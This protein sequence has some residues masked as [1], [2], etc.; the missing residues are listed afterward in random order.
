[1]VRIFFYFIP[2]LR[3]FT[4]CL[5][6]AS[7]KKKQQQQKNTFLWGVPTPVHL[8]HNDEGRSQWVATCAHVGKE[9]KWAWGAHEP[10]NL[11]FFNAWIIFSVMTAALC[12]QAANAKLKAHFE[13]SHCIWSNS[14]Q[15]IKL[16]YSPRLLLTQKTQ[17]K[18]NLKLRPPCWSLRVAGHRCNI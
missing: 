10:Q 6:Q 18:L 12:H 1:M 11:F 4:N 2:N 16:Y 15:A 14:C 17:L 9:K 5:W 7:V 3:V 13:H 8:F